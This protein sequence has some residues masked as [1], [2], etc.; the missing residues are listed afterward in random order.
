MFEFVAAPRLQSIPDVVVYW[1]TFD[2]V[3]GSIHN[4]GVAARAVHTEQHY[5]PSCIPVKLQ[6]L[7]RYK[8]GL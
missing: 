6:L 5:R 2:V 3:E 8:D 1:V 4:T 7:S